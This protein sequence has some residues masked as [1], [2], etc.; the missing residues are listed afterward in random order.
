MNHPG[1]APTISPTEVS[2][3]GPTL[4]LTLSGPDRPGV[5]QTLFQMVAEH[6]V[7]VVDVEQIVMR[8]RLIL[9]VLVAN[10]VDEGHG[11]TSFAAL[12]QGAV[13][14]ASELEMELI[15]SPG[16][17]D[18]QPVRSGRLFVAVLGAP[19]RPA[20]V[21]AVADRIAAHGANIDRIERRAYYPVTAIELLVSGAI[22]VDELRSELAGVSVDQGIDIAVQRSGLH[23]RAKRLVMMDVDS[24]LVQGEA[25]DALAERAGCSDAVQALT[26]A[27]MR[28]EV[29]FAESLRARVALLAGLDAR[30]IDDV[31][32]SLRLSPGARTLVRTLK[33]LGYQCGAVSGG[34]TQV[35][36]GVAGELGLDFTAA[37]EL[38]IVDGRLTGALVGPVID[39]AGK[40]AALKTFAERAGVPLAATVAVGDGAND[41][42]MLA[43]AGL[44]IAFNA[45]PVVRERADAAVNVPYLDAILYLLGISREEVDVADAEDD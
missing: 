33:R 40:A 26:E 1:A 21:A 31:R 44:G 19:L 30:E 43:V 25:I 36:E 18:A 22:G 11:P 7:I 8:G 15:I 34:F 13:R 38:E 16:L 28:G 42:D 5:T 45:K 10:A 2:V 39:R 32:R 24:T 14:V 23:R 12:E 35:I 3:S 6:D 9:A 17:G 41:L 27:A 4:L 37:N 20:A 29:D